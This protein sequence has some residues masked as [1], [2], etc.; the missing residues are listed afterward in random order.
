[1]YL[2]LLT[3]D[4]KRGRV[5]IPHGCFFFHEGD[6]FIKQDFLS[7]FCYILN[8]FTIVFFECFCVCVFVS[9]FSSFFTFFTYSFY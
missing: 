8:D 7:Y 9:F 4:F 6:I 3:R 1:M 2:Y 5:R